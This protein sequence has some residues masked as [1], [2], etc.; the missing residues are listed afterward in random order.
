MQEERYYQLGRYFLKT[1]GKKVRKISVDGGFSC[2]NRDGKLGKSGCVFCDPASFSPSQRDGNEQY[3]GDITAQIDAAAKRLE[4]RFA[5]HNFV[6]YFQPATNTYAPVAELE[7]K[8]REAISHPKVVGLAVG[9]RPDA[10]T[11]KTLDLLEQLASETWVTLELGVQTTFD[12]SLAWLK[13]GH[14]HSTTI[15]AVQR[16]K[17]R[18]IRLGAHL[19]LGVPGENREANATNAKRIAEL[20]FDAVKLHNLHVV[21]GTSL[22]ELYLTGDF[23]PICWETYLAW[24]CDFLELLSPTCVIERVCGAAPLGYL[25]GAEWGLGRGAIH[26]EVLAELERRRTRQGAKYEG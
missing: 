3:A 9:T 18:G 14:T 19:I 21:K 7:E 16:A 4:Q 8:F 20:D 5:V 1:F 17:G 22:E 6:A 23:E 24:V 11:N 12:E 2:P 26:R 25:A 15:D 10:I 13:R